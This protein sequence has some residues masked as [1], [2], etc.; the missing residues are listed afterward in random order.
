MYEIKTHDP[1]AE[2]LGRIETQLGKIVELLEAHETVELAEVDAIG[3][4]RAVAREEV[5]RLSEAVG[6]RDVWLK[7]VP[8]APQPIGLGPAVGHHHGAEP[9]D[10]IAGDLP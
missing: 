1:L 3:Q 10:G 7:I 5:G 2:S 9:D 6:L 4:M 8:G